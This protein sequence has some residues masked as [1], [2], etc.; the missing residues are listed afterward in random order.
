MESAP[1]ER[2]RSAIF[3]R[4]KT[5]AQT[6]Q[7]NIKSPAAEM[8]LHNVV[9]EIEEAN[10]LVRFAKAIQ[11]VP[12][13]LLGEKSYL[14]S[15]VVYSLEPGFQY[16]NICLLQCLAAK[17]NNDYM[18]KINTDLRISS[19]LLVN[20]LT[21]VN[22]TKEKEEG[23]CMASSFLDTGFLQLDKCLA[24]TVTHFK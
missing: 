6:Y 15:M 24:L 9:S 4:G 8:E 11:Y 21:I 5:R 16:S 1:S 2:E 7:V 20:L 13:E 3:S 22:M 18:C 17:T 14:D 12:G 10:E 19:R 23:Y